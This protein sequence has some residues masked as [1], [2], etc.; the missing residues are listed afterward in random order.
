MCVCER[1]FK[2][3]YTTVCRQLPSAFLCEIK[4]GG[5]DVRERSEFPRYIRRISSMCGRWMCVCVCYRCF[6]ARLR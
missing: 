4:G 6:W 2:E 1:D 3:V 5:L